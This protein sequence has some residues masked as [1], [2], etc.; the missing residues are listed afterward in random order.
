M[1]GYEASRDSNPEYIWASD[2]R[3][4]Y[5]RRRGRGGEGDRQAWLNFPLLYRVTGGLGWVD[6]DWDDPSSCPI[7]QQVLLISHLANYCQLKQRQAEDGISD[8]KVNQ[9]QLYE[10]RVWH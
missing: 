1:R 7:A 2:T 6:F 8:I 9:T 3:Y 10:Y 4:S 5:K